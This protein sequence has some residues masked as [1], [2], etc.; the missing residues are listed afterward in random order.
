MRL[1]LAV[2]GPSYPLAKSLVP[3]ASEC[4]VLQAIATMPEWTAFAIDELNVEGRAHAL[5]EK[6]RKS[7]EAL[8]A[9]LVGADISPIGEHMLISLIKGMS[10]EDAIRYSDA[11]PGLVATVVQMNPE[12]AKSPS[13]WKGSAEHQRGLFEAATADDVP[14]DTQNLIVLAMLQAGSD[15]VAERALRKFGPSAV[16]AV[17]C[18]FDASDLQSPSDLR[19][20]WRRG[21]AA[22]APTLLD[23]LSGREKAREA[24]GALIADLSNPHSAEVRQRGGSIWL[25]VLDG[26]GSVPTGATPLAAFCLAFGFD[27]PS[28]RPDELVARTFNAVHS[29][30]AKSSLDDRSWSWLDDHLPTLAIWRYW[31]RCERLRRGLAERF[32]NHDW[33]VA[34]LFRCAPSRDALRDLLK[35]C[36]KV[37]GGR[38]LLKRIR[39][40]VADDE[41]D[42]DRPRREVVEWYA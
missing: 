38:Q 14:A 34:Q 5:W 8:I 27:A 20:G 30:V 32:I 37:D 35:S 41:V 16:H 17:M 6:D 13:L 33:P 25:K 9:W 2:A 1:K 23:W 3:D 39:R 36:D 22:Q 19:D 4:D 21:L 12:L 24:S 7:A 28:G 26:D 10:I 40:A 11:I 31:D 42:L 15:A 29:A 18:W